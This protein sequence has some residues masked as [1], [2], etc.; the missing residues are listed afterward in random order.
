VNPRSVY[1]ILGAGALAIA[2][3]ST[4]LAIA[5]AALQ[6]GLSVAAA[7]LCAALFLVPGL[8][9][10]GHSRRLSS[11]EIALAHTASFATARDAIRIQELADEL[12]V[13]PKDAEQILRTAIREGHLRGRFEGPD[14]FVADKH[15]RRPSE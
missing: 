10:L 12:Q 5:G 4:T 11:R 1:A 13:P 2:G 6:Q 14:R 3:L 7:S 9:F 15:E 8:Y